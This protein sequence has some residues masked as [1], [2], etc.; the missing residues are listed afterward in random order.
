MSMRDDK[1][2]FRWT[3]PAVVGASAFIGIAVYLSMLFAALVLHELG[4]NLRLYHSGLWSLIFFGCFGGS[5][6]SLVVSAFWLGRKV[7][8]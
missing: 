5:L 8:K 2:G 4:E 1:S 7:I 3:R 6:I